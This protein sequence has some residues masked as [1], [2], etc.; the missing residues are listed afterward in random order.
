MIDF[1]YKLNNIVMPLYVLMVV[2]GNLESEV[3]VL[4]L[5]VREDKTTIG[6]LMDAFIKNNDTSNTKCIIEDKDFTEREIFT[7]KIQGYFPFSYI[8]DIQ[9]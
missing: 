7:D 8:T 1:T 9:T 6:H 2:D 3:I 5:V 4:W